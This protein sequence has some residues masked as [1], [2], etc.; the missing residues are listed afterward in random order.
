[1]LQADNILC[2]ALDQAVQ[3][4]FAGPAY[5]GGEGEALRVGGV[6]EGIVRR[7]RL[8]RENVQAGIHNFLQ[9]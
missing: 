7:E 4:F 2:D 5:V 9:K 3:G 1:M 8:G 6:E